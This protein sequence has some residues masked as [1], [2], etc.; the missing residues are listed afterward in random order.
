MS[1]NLK[2]GPEAFDGKTLITVNA[3]PEFCVETIAGCGDNGQIG[4]GAEFLL[5]KDAA[6]DA[7]LDFG[8][9]DSV[10]MAAGSAIFKGAQPGDWCSFLLFAPATAVNSTPGTGDCN[11]VATG[12][13]FNI[14]VPAGGDG[15][16]TLTA[17]VI[18]PNTT[19][20]GYWDWDKP[21]QGKGTITPNPA[22]KGAFDMFDAELPLAQFAN[23]VP[24]IGDGSLQLGIHN[25]R[26]KAL[27]P[28]WKCRV[29][30]HND[31]GAHTVEFA[32]HLVLGR[33]KTV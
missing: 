18:V 4:T 3:F 26:S 7:T 32:W 15:S 27:Y 24:I 1:I 11:L 21:N 16:H 13:G 5:S 10:W 33:E 22:G 2:R 6:G 17:P 19:K 25:V 29:T 31:S 28:F 20:T 8:F 9:I 23:K 30:L 12:L 14:V